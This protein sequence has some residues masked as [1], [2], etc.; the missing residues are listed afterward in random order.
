QELATS[1]EYQQT[2]NTIVKLLVPNVGEAGVLDVAEQN[3]SLRRAA[4]EHHDA[5]S[6]KRL[7]ELI[8]TERRDVP[9][10]IVRIMQSREPHL[11]PPSPDLLA[12]IAGESSN[13]TA[14]ILIMPLV[15]RG[16]AIGVISLLSHEAKPFTPSDLPLFVEIARRASLAIDNAR[17]YLESQQAV[18]AREE[19]LAIVS[20]DLR[21]P[22]NAVTLGASLLKQSEAL[23]EEDREQ[24]DMMDVSARQMARLIA[25]LLDVTRMEG[26]KHLP[27][28]PEPVDVAALLEEAEHL[29]ASQASAAGV[30]LGSR[31]EGDVPRVQADRHRV[32]QVLSNLVGN[33][34]KFTPA[35]GSITLIASPGTREV[36]FS[37]ADDGPGIPAEDREQIFSRFWQAKRAERHG[38][39]LGLAIAKG[40]VE[41]HGGRI[42]VESEEGRGTTFRFTIPACG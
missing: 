26:G 14:S 11:L 7:A 18:R 16:Q 13:D 42:W 29:F 30:G 3:G 34:I 35:S 12:F 23:T 33:A 19:V 37:V 24:I 9:E 38:A 40:I 10:G 5:H 22:L 2:I 21:N 32:I 31:I 41:S 28:E 15:S 27:V 4:T 17:L 8:G 6:A 39:G 36:I 1:L 25:D 20:H